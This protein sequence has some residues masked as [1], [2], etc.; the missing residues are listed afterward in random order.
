MDE[1][2][3]TNKIL[4]G[5]SHEYK[6]LVYVIQAHY[7]LI[8]FDEL[9][10]KLLNFKGSLHTNQPTLDHLPT[11]AIQLI[12]IQIGT[13]FILPAITG[14]R[15]HSLP[16]AIAP[17]RPPTW[18][19]IRYHDEVTTHLHAP[20]KVFVKS[21]A[22]KVTLLKGVILSASYRFKVWDGLVILFV[23]I[24]GF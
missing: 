21:V 1:E 24:F 23:M 7:T 9:H 12:E 13:H 8:T 6:Q 5:S 3:L 15:V 10:E 14:V 16:P 19:Q 22:S 4:D 18:G 20:T 11:A 17:P 2:D